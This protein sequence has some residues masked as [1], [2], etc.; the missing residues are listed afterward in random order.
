[1]SEWTY[2][3]GGLEFSCSPFEI[4]EDFKDVSPKR[5]DFETDEAYEEAVDKYRAAYHKAIYL[6]FPEEQFKLGAP[7]I[8]SVPDKTKKKRK[9]SLG[10][11]SYPEKPA[12]RFDGTVIYSM[13][14]AR[15]IL[16]EA[17]KLFPQ[18]ELGFRYTL[19]QKNVD[20]HSSISGFIHDCLFDYY[21]KA[22]DKMYQGFEGKGW[23]ADWTY[24]DLAKYVRV[25]ED[26]SYES[27]TGIICGII[28]SLRWA[29]ADE[30]ANS[31]EK[32]IAFLRE[33]DISISHGY[34]EWYDS[35]CY[36]GDEKYRWAFR[37]GS[38]THEYDIMKIDWNT[39]ELI[40]RKR[41][42]HP[43]K[44]DGRID[45]DKY[46]TVEE[47]FRDVLAEKKGEE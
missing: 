7:I 34:L 16:E 45:F 39:N 41:Y 29:T 4:R 40:W 38:W 35:C 13:P 24:E 19:E 33:H 25:E 46:V 11:M 44:E 43:K 14:K 22:I 42:M 18:G 30:V 15:P 26:C 9:N 6:P 20:G 3:R 21:H 17:F 12:L 27:A 37:V 5:E 28:T 32:F 8:G 10:F 31:L 2:V 1:M 23:S 36:L 47:S